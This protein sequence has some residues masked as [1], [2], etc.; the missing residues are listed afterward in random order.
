MR[1]AEC[2]AEAQ[3]EARGWRAYLTHD[4]PP[5]VVTFCHECAEREFED[6]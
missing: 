4:D 2:D 5:E 3:E 6:E 1:C